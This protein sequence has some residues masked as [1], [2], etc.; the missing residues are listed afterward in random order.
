MI[1]LRFSKPKYASYLEGAI[2]ICT[3]DCT[4]LY[5]GM[6]V[7][8]FQVVGKALCSKEDTVDETL[9]RRIAESK[10]KLLAYKKASLFYGPN[11]YYNNKRELPIVQ[12]NIRAYEKLAR[13]KKL[14]QEHLKKLCNE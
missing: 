7:Q 8:E 13:C 4:L 6:T 10:A 3:Y 2:N 14:E 5:N 1:K 11:F 9:G 12:E